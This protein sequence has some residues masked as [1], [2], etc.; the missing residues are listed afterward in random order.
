M[1]TQANCVIGICSGP[2]RPLVSFFEPNTPARLRVG[3]L[4]SRGDSVPAFGSGSGSGWYST[5]VL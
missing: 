3:L 5:S 1:R 2:C 4:K